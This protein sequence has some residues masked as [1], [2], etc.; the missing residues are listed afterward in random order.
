MKIGD[1]KTIRQSDKIVRGLWHQSGTITEINERP[2]TA[3]RSKQPTQYFLRFSEPIHTGISR[4][5]GV[6]V[7]PEMVEGGEHL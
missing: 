7:T 4:M 1:K 3:T 5:A 2:E 6:W